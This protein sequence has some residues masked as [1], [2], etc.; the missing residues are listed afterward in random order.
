MCSIVMGFCSIVASFD[1][2][3]KKH[4]KDLILSKIPQGGQHH[5]NV[6]LQTHPQGGQHTEIKLI[7]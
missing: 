7:P 5:R 2:D 4:Q 1:E 6:S 3:A